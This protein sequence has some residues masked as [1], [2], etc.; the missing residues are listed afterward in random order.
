MKPVTLGL[1]GPL[2][3]AGAAIGQVPSANDTSDVNG[4]TGMGSGALGG[5][6]ATHSGFQNT[7]SGNQA[8]YNDT[9]GGNNT[10][11]GY[12]AL[13]YNATGDDNAAFGVAALFSNTTGEGNTASGV[14]ALFSS[15]SGANNTASG[16]RALFHNTTGDG[17]S[18]CGANALASNTNGSG[19][20]GVGLNTL[21]HNING[22]GNATF[23]LNA[24]YNNT[25]GN[26]NTASG[27]GAM[28]SNTTGSDNIALGFQ[29]GTNLTTGSYNI[30]IGNLGVAA[31]SGVIRI[32][33]AS[34]QNAT[35]IEGIYNVPLSGNAVVV[36]STGQLGV[37][38]VSSERF[39]V[40]I[41]PMGLNTV[42]LQELRPV[43]FHLKT[44]PNG[45]LQ[46][47]L[48]AEEVAQVYPELVIR[49]QKGRID[50]VRYDELAPMLL[51]EIQRQAAEI[52][53]IKQR[54]AELEVLKQELHTTL[55]KLRGERE[56][57]LVAKR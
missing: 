53:D 39:K 30:D 43:T 1:L 28:K 27:R 5:P 47:G 34:A 14:A 18:A 40:G 8:L 50:G 29:A 3:I 15:T 32:G 16:Y 13:Y 19:N 22:N 10:A 35:Y 54:M 55:R 7:A 38:G 2:L 36:T 45:A 25:S 17:N 21:Y 57:E 51:R 4:N 24:L 11:S 26:N 52:D 12:R 37:A 23:G 33:T 9:T 6:T 44:D 56:R 20:S 49:D 41:A 46:Y 42:K 31:E 48:I